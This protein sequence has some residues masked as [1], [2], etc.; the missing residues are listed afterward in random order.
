MELEEYT[1][2]FQNTGT[3]NAINVRLE[4]S[5]SAYVD[6]TTFEFISAS[7]TNQWYL[8]NGKLIVRYDNIRLPDSGSNL[9]SSTGYFKYRIRINNNLL[10]HDSILNFADIYFDFNAPVRTN[11]VITKVICPVLS[12]SNIHKGVSCFGAND[13]YA[14]IVVSGGIEPYSYYW[15]GDTVSTNSLLENISTGVYSVNA[16]DAFG[17]EVN[18]SFT[19]LEPPILQLFAIPVH[20]IPSGSATGS[21]NLLVAGGVGPYVYTWNTGDTNEDVMN[22]MPGIYSVNVIDAHGCSEMI[23]VIIQ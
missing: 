22:L 19:I 11:T 12:R 23:S 2:R 13:G 18:A 10:L 21:I 6:L 9:E 5:L 14:R 20:S 16:V 3:S 17:C 15:N 1:I 4:D 8:Q 7:H